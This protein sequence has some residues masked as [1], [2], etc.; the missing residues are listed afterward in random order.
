M[1]IS[2]QAVEKSKPYAMFP[3]LKGLLYGE[4]DAEVIF[5]EEKLR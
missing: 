3:E 5:S 1:P 2:K 4:G